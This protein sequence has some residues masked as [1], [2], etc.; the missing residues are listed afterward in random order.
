VIWYTIFDFKVCK[1]L[2]HRIEGSCLKREY[3]PAISEGH[4]PEDGG[5]TE[6]G[7]GNVLLLSIP[8]SSEFLNE[9]V[10]TFDYAWL[11]SKEIDAYIFCFRL[12][13]GMEFGVIFH[14]NHAG[15]LLL[16]AQAYDK[17]TI[18]ITDKPFNAI[19]EDSNY[20]SFRDIVINRQSIAGW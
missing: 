3:K 13:S 9:K 2:F 16:D 14:A 1:D 4:N 7:Y 6:D 5:W 10:S 15:K 20:I 17:F 18:T 8:T 19:T 11:Y 12:P